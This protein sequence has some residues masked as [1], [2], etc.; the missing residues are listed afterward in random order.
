MADPP[1]AKPPSIVFYTMNHNST[2]YYGDQNPLKIDG[3][4]DPAEAGALASWNTNNRRQAKIAVEM[5]E[6]ID[7]SRVVYN[8][9]SGNLGSMHT[10]NI[11][12]NSARAGAERLAGALGHR[13]RQARLLRRVGTATH[14]VVVELPGAGLHLDH[15]G[16][17]AGVGFGIRRPVCG[18]VRLRHDVRESQV[19]D[20]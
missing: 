15:S 16:L 20:S 11:Y 18:P 8:H 9:Q 13:R 2:G 5:A 17:T 10:V 12:L 1:S 3:K 4:Y 7:P 6:R 19:H 14:F